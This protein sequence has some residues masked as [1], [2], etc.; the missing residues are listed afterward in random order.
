MS[1]D[2]V[3]FLPEGFEIDGLCVCWDASTVYYVSLKLNSAG[4]T[5]NQEEAK[6]LL[7]YRFVYRPTD[8]ITAIGASPPNYRINRWAM[9]KFLMESDTSGKAL[10]DMKSQLKVFM[11]QGVYGKYAFSSK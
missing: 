6:M 8:T 9:V 1:E 11:S 5:T 7:E 3:T 10:F 2:Q 4:N